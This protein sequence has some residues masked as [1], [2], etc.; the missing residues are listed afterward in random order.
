MSLSGVQNV[1]VPSFDPTLRRLDEDGI[2]LD[3]RHAIAHGFSGT[4]LAL[5]AGLSPDEMRRFVEV[6][7]DEAADALRVGIEMPIDSFELARDVMMFAHDAGATHGVLG[8]PVGWQPAGE[9]EITAAYTNLA[10]A[11]GLRLVLPVGQVGFAA[12]IG[13]GV[14]WGAWARLAELDNVRGVHITT[15]MPHVLFAALEMF[16]GGLEIGI[17]TPALLGAMPLLAREYD[18]RWLSAAQWEMWQSPDQPHIV[19]FLEHVVAGRKQEALDVHWRLAPAREIAFAAG[20]LDPELDGMP[21]WPLAKYVSW[22]V[23]GNGGVTREPALHVRPHQFE[24]RKAMLRALGIDSR[25]DENEFL[26]GQAAAAAHRP[27]SA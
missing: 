8:V 4:L 10:E 21:H 11:G 13:G 18:V 6:A 26:E 17:G 9:D 15:W 23:G 22:S 12:H 27:G 25:T 5:N 20:L 2:R 24:A 19:R 14:P 7:I 16:R 1:T 3:I